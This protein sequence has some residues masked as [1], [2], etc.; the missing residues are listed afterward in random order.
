M[1]RVLC[2][3]GMLFLSTAA[4]ADLNVRDFGA[5]G[6]STTD[7]TAAFQKA[8]DDA[9]KT[10]DI[11]HV[12]PGRYAIHGHIAIPKSVTLQ[13]T[14][15]APPATVDSKS[16]KGSML[17][18]YEGKGKDSGP[19]FI[20]LHTNSTIKGI[21][22]FYPEQTI[23]VQPYPWCVHGSGDDCSI[24]NCL[25]IN[26][27]QAVDFGTDPC[28]RHF[29][30]GLYAQALKTGLLI[31]KCY[32]VGRISNIHF[33]P[34]WTE[35]LMDW[36]KKNGTAFIIARTD[37]EYVN[38][39]FAI[40]YNVGFHFRAFKDGP[41]NAIL[42]ESGSDIGPC[43]VKVDETQGHAGVSFVNSQFMCG[44][45]VAP[46]NAGPVKFTACGFWG[47]GKTDTIAKLNGSGLTTFTACHFIS[48]GQVNQTAPA[49]VAETGSV[50]LNGCEFLDRE[51]EK[52]HLQLDKAVESAIIM[53]NR[54]R[55]KPQIK[56][57]SE[58]DVQIGLNSG[59]K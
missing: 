55:S 43:A 30:D 57:R 48:W 9:G 11:V 58:G 6:D 49:I 42:T 46:T 12:P 1:H 4:F 35:S 23:D 18:A 45:E 27:Y 44:V 32:D 34:F 26:P 24:I 14:F 25:L 56:N 47:Y 21:I 40:S 20:T 38:N 8:L 52:V 15:T 59:G 7:D 10:G 2:V 3:I 5:K 39:C 33:W 41:G 36:T 28:G 29:I 22:V 17:L 53:G 31:D 51:P 13:G 37:W 19:A 16:S 54:F 50:T